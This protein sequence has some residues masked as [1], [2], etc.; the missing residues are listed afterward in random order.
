[1]ANSQFIILVVLQSVRRPATGSRRPI[2]SGHH[3][4]EVMVFVLMWLEL[5]RK[6]TDSNTTDC[7]GQL[8]MPF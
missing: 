7:W 1:L 2:I 4:G 3:A 5:G 8:T 6:V